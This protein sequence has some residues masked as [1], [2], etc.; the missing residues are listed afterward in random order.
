[1]KP[2]FNVTLC[3]IICINKKKK[4]KK[5]SFPPFNCFYIFSNSNVDLDPKAPKRNPKKGLHKLF[6]YS[7]FG[8]IMS[9]VTKDIQ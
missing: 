2:V 1:M 3:V 8:Y 6:L 7:T 5:K 9:I 4:K